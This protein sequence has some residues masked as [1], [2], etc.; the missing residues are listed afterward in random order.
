[1]R[2]IGFAKI[3]LEHCKGQTDTEM[4][5]CAFDGSESGYKQC[6]MELLNIQNALRAISKPYWINCFPMVKKIS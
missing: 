5:D 4:N 6:A 1:M 2:P 3:T